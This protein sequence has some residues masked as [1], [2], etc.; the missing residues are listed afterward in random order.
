MAKNIS[1]VQFLRGDISSRALPVRP[2]WTQDEISFT[3]NCTR[4]GD[5]IKVCETNI[6]HKGQGGF[7]EINFAKGECTF[8]AACVQACKEDVFISTTSEPW[9][10]KAT[11]TEDCLAD[12]GV[13]CMICGEQ[14]E[15]SAI[16]FIHQAGK[17]DQ[18]QM[19]SQACNGCGACYQSCPVQAIKVQEIELENTKPQFNEQTGQKLE[20][21]S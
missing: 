1:R 10:L 5:C 4:C 20:A 11:I 6:L 19:D 14:C 3:D 9:D 12:R 2:P 13:V 17:V 18:P 16:R 8:C 21:Y 7:P 15:T